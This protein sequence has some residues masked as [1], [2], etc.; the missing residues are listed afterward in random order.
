MCQEGGCGC[1]VVA[2]TRADP[3]AGTNVT[4]AVNSV[5]T[6]ADSPLLLSTKASGFF[7]VRNGTFAFFNY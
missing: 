7:C 5:S 4:L 6:Q 2:L 3:L 1:C